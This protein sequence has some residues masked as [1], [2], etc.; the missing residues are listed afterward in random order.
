MAIK[1]LQHSL[2]EKDI[3]GSLR[4]WIEPK[5]DLSKTLPSLAIRTAV[6]GILV[7]LPCEADHLKRTQGNKKPIGHIILA[8][9]KHKSETPENKRILKELMEKW[10]RPVFGKVMKDPHCNNLSL[11]NHTVTTLLSLPTMHPSFLA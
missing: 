9:R 11:L 2:L 7:K 1:S 5:N 3:L 6:Y 8:L 4:D 10:C